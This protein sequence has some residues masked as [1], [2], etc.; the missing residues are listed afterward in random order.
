MRWLIISA[1]APPII[2][3]VASWVDDV[4]RTLRQFDNEV[5][6]FSHLGARAGGS[7]THKIWGRNWLALQHIWTWISAR[8]NTADAVIFSTWELAIWLAPELKRR[9]SRIFI[10]SHGSDVTR[11]LSPSDQQRILQLDVIIDAWIPV[12]EYLSGRLSALGCQSLKMVLPMPLELECTPL[13]FRPSDSLICVARS[14]PHKGIDASI[15]LAKEM[16]RALLLIGNHQNKGATHVSIMDSLPRAQLR[17]LFSNS[18]AALLLSTTDEHGRYAEGL[19]LCLLEAAAAGC[20]PI[21][22]NVGGIPEAIGA[23]ILWTEQSS[24]AQIN[25]HLKD[26][27]LRRKCWNWVRDC[28]GEQRWWNGMRELI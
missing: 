7:T 28:R 18:S 14:T 12:S 23:G 17:T 19:G 26:P 6:V 15:A 27:Q 2:G 1:E 4:S 20:P 9:N 13:N 16:K 21:G 10:A 8:K 11:I 22:S 5:T 24:P 25:E 3:G